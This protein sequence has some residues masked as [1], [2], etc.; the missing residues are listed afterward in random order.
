MKKVLLS[1]LCF[2]LFTGITFSKSPTDQG[3][4]S[5]SGGASY[6]STSS[7]GSDD[8]YNVITLAPGFYYF[9]MP[10]LA[11]GGTLTYTNVSM[12]DYSSTTT[13]LGPGVKYFFNVGNILAFASASYSFSSIK[14]KDSDDAHK[15]TDIALGGGVEFFLSRNVS[16][17]PFI[18]YHIMSS[19]YGDNEA[20]DES[21]LVVGLGIGVFIY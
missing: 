9:A 4:Y 16:L 17:E 11:V 7:E 14:I 2:L 1:F 10:N 6:S 12:G 5:I 21:K 13:G 20:S 8:N 3:V 19:K 18:G 15:Y